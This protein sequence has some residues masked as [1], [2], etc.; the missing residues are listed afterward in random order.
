VTVEQSNSGEALRQHVSR[1]ESVN[2][3]IHGLQLDRKE[4][5]DA[6]KGDGFDTKTIRKLIA[7]RMKDEQKRKEENELLATYAAALGL[8][9]FA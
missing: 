3:Q 6:A 9:P 2:A 5:F 7:I 1:I 8:D 4:L